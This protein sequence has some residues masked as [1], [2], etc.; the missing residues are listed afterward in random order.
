MCLL[1]HLC[2][3]EIRVATKLNTKGYEVNIRLPQHAK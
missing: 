3:I 1:M 2:G